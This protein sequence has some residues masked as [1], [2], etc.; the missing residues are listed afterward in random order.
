MRTNPELFLFC[1]QMGRQGQ[2]R[3]TL[4]VWRN[5][6]NV[7][8]FRVCR[9][10]RVHGYVYERRCRQQRSAERSILYLAASQ[11][12]GLQRIVGHSIYSTESTVLAK[13]LTTR[14]ARTFQILIR[15]TWHGRFL[16]AAKY[17]K[18]IHNSR[19][20]VQ[21]WAG[22]LPGGWVNRVGRNF[23]W[24]LIIQILNGF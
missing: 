10:C 21:V 11:A 2:T 20:A 17:K 5:A 24:K 8:L 19:I 18:H 3:K 15:F 6:I 23:D 7:K 14:R 9:I 16:F 22:F 12:A 4:S 13:M 1:R